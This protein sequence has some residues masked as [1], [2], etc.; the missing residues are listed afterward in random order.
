MLAEAQP[1]R[2]SRIPARYYK[3]RHSDLYHLEMRFRAYDD[4]RFYGGNPESPAF[5]ELLIRWFQYST[6]CPLFSLHGNRLIASQE[7]NQLNTG[8]PNEAWSFGEEAY[9]IIKDLL[10]LRERLRPYILEQMHLAQEKGIP[11]MRPLFF[12]FPADEASTTIDDEFLFGPDLL[13]A[14]V[15][16]EGARSLRVYL[17]GGTIWRDAWTG[18]TFEGG[19]YVTAEAPLARIPLY[20]RANAHLPIRAE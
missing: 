11:P 5:R 2:A 13:V 20:L 18:Q 19:Q 16:Q 12:D 6:F 15:L 9:A 3:A 14:P 8:G 17:P 1:T 7:P 4:E 10:F